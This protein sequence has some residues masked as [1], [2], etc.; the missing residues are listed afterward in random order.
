MHGLK[1]SLQSC[2]N[3]LLSPNQQTMKWKW[4]VC[5][6]PIIA[7]HRLVFHT[8]LLSRYRWAE[9][10]RGNRKARNKWRW[11]FLWAIPP[12]P[13]WVSFC[14]CWQ[15]RYKAM[16]IDRGTGSSTKSRSKK[17]GRIQKRH[18]KN[19]NVFVKNAYGVKQPSKKR[20][21][22][23]VKKKKLKRIG[24]KLLDYDQSW[25][26]ELGCSLSLFFFLPPFLFTIPKRKKLLYY[27]LFVSRILYISSS[28]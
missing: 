17:S 12:L 25:C 8:Y 10:T 7:C 13:V 15:F 5:V 26:L 18:T 23:W 27:L 20:K 24:I 22:K 2:R 14:L 6:L 9:Q 11:L 16:D 19:S 3:S 28:I 21:W 1:D 4:M